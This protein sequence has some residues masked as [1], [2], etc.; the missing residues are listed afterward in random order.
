M[1][2]IKPGFT[3]LFFSV[4]LMVTSCI[5][6]KKMDDVVATELATKMQ[7]PKI[8]NGSNIKVNSA[9]TSNITTTSVTQTKTSNM[10]P[11]IVYWKW[12]YKNICNLNPQIPVNNFIKTVNANKALRDKIKNNKLELTV[13]QAPSQFTLND[14]SVVILFSFIWEKVTVNTEEKDLVVSYKLLAEDNTPAKNGTIT[15]PF[16]KAKMNVSQW[17]SWKKSI[18]DYLSDYDTY[19]AATSKEFTDVLIAQL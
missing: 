9:I 3:V 19:I 2:S 15:I 11:L 18:A 16:G 14:R 6:S 12:D 17:R 5:T 1:I 13:E 4:S 8:K 10:V 7:P